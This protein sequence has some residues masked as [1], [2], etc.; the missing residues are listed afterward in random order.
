MKEGM[1]EGGVP[2]FW[3]PV[4]HDTVIVKESRKEGRRG[5]MKKGG[6]RKEGREGGREAGRKTKEGRKRGGK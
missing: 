1:K 5:K 4:V 6:E 3:C 2:G